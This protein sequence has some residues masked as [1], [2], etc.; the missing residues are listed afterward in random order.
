MK[1]DSF[2]YFQPSISYL[3]APRLLPPTDSVPLSQPAYLFATSN[4]ANPVPTDT[5]SLQRGAI[6]F[7]ITCSVCHGSQ[8][9]G[10]GPVVKFWKPAALRPVDLTQ[11][12]YK[13]LPDGAIYNFVSQGIGL[14][15]PLRENLTD[16]ERWDVINYVRS[17]QQ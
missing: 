12:A 2:M 7:N 1:F 11:A 13:G 10:D 16:R 6:L 14:M 15:P 17:L 5:V 8:G 4:P 9:K 3:E